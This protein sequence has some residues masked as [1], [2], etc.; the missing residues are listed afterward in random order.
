VIVWSGW[1]NLDDDPEHVIPVAIDA[2]V[3]AARGWADEGRPWAVLMAGEGDSWELPWLGTGPAPWL[4]MSDEYGDDLA[5][6]DDSWGSDAEI[7][8][9]SYSFDEDKVGHSDDQFGHS[10]DQ[11]SHSDDQFSHSDDQFS[12]W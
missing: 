7:A 12:N 1:D 9:D 2:L 6:D 3:T 8:D 11:F 5:L 10:D 4:S